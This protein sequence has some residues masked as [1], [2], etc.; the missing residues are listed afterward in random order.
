VHTKQVIPH[1]TT[2]GNSVVAGETQAAV[3][4]SRGENTTHAQEIDDLLHME[5]IIVAIGITITLCVLWF[6]I[7]FILYQITRI[8]LPTTI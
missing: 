1:P 5:P 4:R 3:H 7:V 8:A 2:D 6:F